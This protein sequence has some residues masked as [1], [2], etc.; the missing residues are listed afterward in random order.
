[1]ALLKQLQTG[2][3]AIYP[4]RCLT[5]GA[6]VDGDFGLCGSCWGDT[7]FI[8]GTVCDACGT[9]LPGDDGGETPLCDACMH[10][11]RPWKRGRAA[12]LY[13]GNGRKLVLALKHGDRQEIARPAGLWLAQVAGRLVSPNTLIAPVPLHWQRMIKRRYNQSALLA[14]SLS[15]QVDRPV[16]LDLLQRIRRTRSL[17]GLGREE[18][19]QMLEG[20]IRVHLRRRHRLIGRPVLLVDDVMTSGATLTACTQACLDAGSGPVSVVT[21]ARVA[22]DA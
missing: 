19:M 1:M 7:F 12:L 4:P 18:R 15:L 13:R 16:C 2:L 22:K 14:K 10:M 5:C 17:D 3:D 8:G 20:S 11:P 9:P 21:L 6:M